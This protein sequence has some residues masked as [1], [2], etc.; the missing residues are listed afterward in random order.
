MQGRKVKKFLQMTAGL[1]LLVIVL[2]A[3]VPST[4][5]SRRASNKAASLFYNSVQEGN[6][7][8][9]LDNPVILSG[10]KNFSDTYSFAS[11][12]SEQKITDGQFLVGS[13]S[14]DGTGVG[15]VSSCFNVLEKALSEPITYK[16]KR[17][18]YGPGTTEWTQLQTFFLL[19]KQTASY[20]TSLRDIYARAWSASYQ[21]SIPYNLF[22]SGANWNKN[23]ILT[24]YS[25]NGVINSA[26]FSPANFSVNFGQIENHASVLMV[27]DPAVVYH[28]TG[29]ALVSLMMNMRN[30]S[31]VDRSELGYLLYDEAGAINEGLSDYF[32]YYMNHRTHFA[33]WALGRFLNVSRPLT[34]SDPIH[35][36]GISKD[37]DA[38]LSYP[39]YLIYDPNYHN[40]VIEEIHNAGMITSH[41]LVALGEEL[42]TRCLM[43]QTLSIETTIRY[44]NETLAELGDLTAEG[45][46]GGS[47]RVNLNSTSS[48]EWIKT[49]NPINYHTF[50]QTLA[51]YL[52]QTYGTTGCFPK[53]SIEK[54]F[55]KYGLLLFKTYNE[56]GNNKDLG[57]SGTHTAVDQ[58][59]RLRSSLISK[60][61]IKFDP[62]TNAPQA[63]VFDDPAEM[64]EAIASLQAGGQIGQLSN[65][66]PSDLSYNNGNS[67][68]SPG[69]VVGLA[70]N[71]YNSS[72][73]AMAGVQVLANDWDHFNIDTHPRPCS[74]MGDSFPLESEGGSVDGDASCN[75]VTRYNGAMKTADY[76][77][78]KNEAI[79]PVCFVQQIN[80]G[81]SSQWVSQSELASSLPDKSYCLSGASNTTDCFLRAIKGADTAY[82]S[83]IGPNSTWVKSLTNGDKAPTYTYSNIIFFEVNSRTPPGTTFNCRFRVRFSN[84]EDCYHDS[85]N[86]NDNYLDYEY[87]GSKPFK[88]LDLQFSVTE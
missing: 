61:L 49:A 24:A 56:D 45:Q 1:I 66:T 48:L 57:H 54:L 21:T 82:Y 81:G 74:N 42:Q 62:T 3:C 59:N 65:Q 44:I 13:C 18:G 8:V 68:V 72:N 79:M 20:S 19:K 73:T 80:T 77:V 35:M 37:D 33:E 31:R 25:N 9:L 43:N 70:L 27:Q 5:N 40:L 47:D 34:E 14:G 63:F 22:S 75:Y 67:Q 64:R 10:N 87:S 51:K 38:R 50:Y 17:W 88:V 11:F 69:E 23:Q 16:N 28:E 39:T 85:A 36:A 29:H 53:D 15:D 32:G 4:N 7:M 30:S 52:Y 55:D 2:S 12:L 78:D 60:N 76:S 46:D 83:Y 41:F 86:S 58:N 26:F 6:G 84:C 71:L